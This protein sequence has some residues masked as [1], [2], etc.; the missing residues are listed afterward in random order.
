M[1]KRK[2][3]IILFLSSNYILSF[4]QNDSVQRD[5][6]K[7]VIRDSAGSVN[8]RST[9]IG[10]SLELY[11]S[12]LA[13]TKTVIIKETPKSNI[14]KDILPVITLILG[15]VLNRFLDLYFERKRIKKVGR[16][17]IAELSLLK[18]PIEKQLENLDTFIQQ[19]TI[20]KYQMPALTTQVALN[21]DNFKALD[22]SDL[23]RYLDKFKFKN[24]PD[25]VKS[26]N[27]VVSTISVLGSH[28]ENLN[29]KFK[30]FLS[31]T[32]AGNTAL[33]KNLQNLV[34]AFQEYLRQIFNQI[35]SDPTKYPPV[36]EICNLFEKEIYPKQST[37]D[38]DIYHLRDHFFQPLYLGLA[39][40]LN[41]ER[42]QDLRRLTVACIN[43]IHAINAERIYMLE[44]AKTLHKRYKRELSDLPDL[45]NQIS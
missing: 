39:P 15:V 6:S 23:L 26:A 32:S 8:Q 21:G 36:K 37:G 10:D 16:Q 40:L 7:L 9:F 24:Y 33:T 29:E 14:F 19:I 17:W 30:L 2:L 28:Y 27:N 38:Y 44:I 3:F 43:D 12:R 45:I 4:A 34:P 5:N 41:D 25:A 18:S 22:K 42:T 20:E 11:L 1:S 13:E 35:G 31:Q